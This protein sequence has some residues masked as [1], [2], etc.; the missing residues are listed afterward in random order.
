[1]TTDHRARANA[2]TLA[3]FEA[4]RAEW[5]HVQECI[6]R[7][8]VATPEH[9]RDDATVIQAR[10]A[11]RPSAFGLVDPPSTDEVRIA[12][13]LWERA[14]RRA[15][16]TPRDIKRKQEARAVRFRSAKRLQKH[17]HPRP[18]PDPESLDGK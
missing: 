12:I 1:M 8:I 2:A 3:K 4:R 9:E 18:T 14:A 5:D 11:Q 7:A 13:Q 6:K 17:T 10:I 15:P 16:V